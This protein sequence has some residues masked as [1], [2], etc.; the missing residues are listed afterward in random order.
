MNFI[1]PQNY[2]YQY[3]LLGFLDFSIFITNILWALF[4]Y[5]LIN[6]I[7]SSLIIK[8]YLFIIFYFPLFLLSITGFN[9]EN[10]F[11]VLFYIYKFKKSSKIYCYYSD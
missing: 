10:I 8:I 1:F 3:K 9:N 5:C 4:V 11:Y 2:K 7:F 6:L